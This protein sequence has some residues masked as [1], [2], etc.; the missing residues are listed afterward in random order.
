MAGLLDDVAVYDELTDG[1]YR[2]EEM[3]CSYLWELCKEKPPEPAPRTPAITPHEQISFNRAALRLYRWAVRDSATGRINAK[4]VTEA[5]RSDYNLRMELG[6]PENPKIGFVHG[7]LHAM[8]AAVTARDFTERMLRLRN[9]LCQLEEDKRAAAFPT[10]SPPAK[11]GHRVPLT[12]TSRQLRASGSPALSPPRSPPQTSPPK[13]HRSSQKGKAAAAAAG[14]GDDISP[15]PAVTGLA[16]E[17]RALYDWYCWFG[18]RLNVGAKCKGLRR[19]Q[20]HQMLRDSGLVGHSA[21]IQPAL[22]DCVLER[23]VGKGTRYIPFPA[24]VEALC[25]VA[26]RL[27]AS[28]SWMANTYVVLA[29]FLLP[30]ASSQASAKAKAAWLSVQAVE[31]LSSSTTKKEKNP[32]TSEEIK[33]PEEIKYWLSRLTALKAV[34][35]KMLTYE[36]QEV[37]GVPH[38]RFGQVIETEELLEKANANEASDAASAGSFDVH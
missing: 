30:M 4:Q 16:G 20:F 35:D 24:F 9:A 32:R 8:P 37:F 5:I 3:I 31:P 18:D 10:L 25:G 34:E 38:D 7:F 27:D 13:S 14:N 21:F 29:R 12:P 22:V 26:A 19:R 33:V 6:I 23:V 2:T 11:A 28:R 1:A 15:I 17:L 36:V